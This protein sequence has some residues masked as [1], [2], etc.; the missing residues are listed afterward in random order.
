MNA[1]ASSSR[2]DVGAGGRK[3]HSVHSPQ[4]GFLNKFTIESQKS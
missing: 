1:E 4:V 2:N 3:Q